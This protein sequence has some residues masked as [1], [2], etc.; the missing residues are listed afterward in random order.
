MSKLECF[1]QILRSKV[2]CI[3]LV[4]H[5]MHNYLTYSETVFL[6][7]ASRRVTYLATLYWT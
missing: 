2:F 3:H 6:C 7:V 4:G 5:F 1:P